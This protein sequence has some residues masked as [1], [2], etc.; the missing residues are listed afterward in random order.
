[1]TMIANIPGT[2][3]SFVG[4]KREI[5][6]VAALLTSSRL[7][8]ITGT[9]GC[10][11]ARLA[12][13]IA[14]ETAG[15]Y[16][17]G[18]QWIDVAPVTDAALVPQTIAR[19][20]HVTEQSDSSL[21]LTL[22]EGLQ[23]K[24][25]LLV[26]VNCE[27]VLQACARVAEILL[28]STDVRILATSREPLG[29]AGERRYPLPPLATPAVALSV[30]ELEQF[31]AVR[32]FAERARLILPDFA[33]TAENGA[34]VADICRHLDGLPL[35]IELA[36]ARVNVLTPHQI[37]A[38]LDD[39]FEL[40]APATH[41]T[42]SHH[43]TLRAA[44]DWSYDL[45]TAAEQ[46]LLR[47]LSVFSGGWSLATAQIVCSGDGITP[48]QVLDVLSSL[49]DKSLVVARTLQR[50]E[51]R[52]TLLETI[53]QYALHRTESAGELPAL[54]SKHLQCFLRL[55]EE[56]APK[57]GGAYQKLWLAWLEEEHENVRHALAWS[58][59]S[60]R[61]EDGLRIAVAIYQFWTIRDYVRDGLSWMERLLAQAS[62]GVSAAVRANALAY[63]SFLAGFRGNRAAQAAYGRQAAALART[64]GEHGTSALRWALAAESYGARAAGDYT[65]E[66]ALDKQVIALNRELDDRYQLGLT[67]STASFSAMSLG[68]YATARAMLDEG[69]T[70]LRE[71]GNPYR[72]A[73]ALNFSGDLARLEQSYLPAQA[74]Y[75]E[76]ITLLRD[77]NAMRDLASALHNLGHTCLHLG[78]ARRAAELFTESM[79]IHQA[80]QNGPGMAECL[81]GFAAL[82]IADEGPGDG[83]RLLAAATAIGGEGIA[84]AWAATRMEYEYNLALARAGLSAPAFDAARAAGSAL[85]LQQAID[86]AH[87]LA[88]RAAASAPG[89][90]AGDDLT[91]REREVAALIA[92]AKSNGD[93]A[94]EL[95]L[96][97][98]TVEKHIANILAKLGFGNRSQI[99][100]WAI[101]SATPPSTGL[102][103]P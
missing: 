2:F 62:E 42:H 21:E 78:D 98:R 31:D 89:S 38:R 103:G 40:L 94:D 70:L 9:A 67:L 24:Q 37:H 56:A 10:G 32:L 51:A 41:V 7:V 46:A 81:I 3:T 13:E 80:Q 74:A 83:A 6:E 54:R 30:S 72:I 15:A 69:L 73:M 28:S 5:A 17:D 77:Q 25:L 36:A 101:D 85:S 92:Q 29:V 1:M 87:E 57:L 43:Q 96:S 88:L 82:A 65:T 64:A 90:R 48:A 60:H 97:K 84:S 4:R 79:A 47:R 95:V 99:M 86:I 59:E 61:I 66:L 50:G 33:V 76:S 71:A 27:Q 68:E 44:I 100:R 49:V 34:D 58:L 55:T 35:A 102:K 91:T 16:A 39:R 93:I 8:T 14:A 45:L 63:A 12:R 19:A 23:H 22:L 75:E 26:L 52:Y 18:V 11:K 20:L 53:R